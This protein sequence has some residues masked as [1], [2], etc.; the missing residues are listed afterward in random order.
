[1]GKMSILERKCRQSGLKLTN[2][3]RIV[4]QVLSEAVDHPDVDEV[5]KRAV[6]LSA[7]ISIATVYRTV[8]MFEE[9]GLI[10]KHSF[11]ERGARYEVE[12]GEHHDHLID[13]Y[14]GDV[15]EFHEEEIE[16]LQIKIAEKHGYELVGHRMELYGKRIEKEE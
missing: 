6:A 3:R 12:S 13:V 15:I 4:A 9:K 14:S 10:Q 1:M 5:Y 8:R 7:N 11:G 16:I 2:Q